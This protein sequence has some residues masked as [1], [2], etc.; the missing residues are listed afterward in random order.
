MLR[1]CKGS[2]HCGAIRYEVDID[3]FVSTLDDVS[4]DELLSGPIRC[5]DGLHDSWANPPAET[6]HL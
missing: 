4:A 5:S 6:R 2:C 3:Q 1:T